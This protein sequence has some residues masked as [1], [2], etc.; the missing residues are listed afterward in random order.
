MSVTGT[1][2][3]AQPPTEPLRLHIGGE[4][5]REGWKIL[6]I[7][8]VP[9][10]DYIGNCRDLSQFPDNSVEAIYASHVYEHLDFARELRAAL[11][12]AY[13][14][15]HPGGIFRA[16]VPDLEVLCRLILAPSL[17]TE[18][19]FHVQRM[20]MG[21]QTDPY[22]YHKVGLTFEFF[23]DFLK[24]VG[25]R[26]IRRVQEFGLFADTTCQKFKGMRISLNVMALK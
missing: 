8:S 7:K 24:L 5:P 23:R 11:G 25:F 22:D 3:Q 21:G 12:E 2:P 9:G 19:R 15:L 20:I 17:T 6:N 1:S 13:R 10:V 18:E 26:D 14:V 4:E 16:G